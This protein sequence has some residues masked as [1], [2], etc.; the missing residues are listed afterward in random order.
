MSHPQLQPNDGSV[1]RRQFLRR[2]TLTV[3]GALAWTNVTGAEPKGRRP[4]REQAEVPVAGGDWQ[5]AAGRT[6]ALR[7]AQELRTARPRVVLD[8][9]WEFAYDRNRTA[10][11]E[12]WSAVDHPLPDS[13]RVPGCAQSEAHGAA[14]AKED[15]KGGLKWPSLADAWFRRRFEVPAAWQ[16]APVVLHVGGVHPAAEFWLNGQSLGV[17]FSS[18]SPLRCDVTAHVRWGAENVL[19]VRVF[20]PE[21]PRLD[22]LWDTAVMAWSGIYRS[23]WVERLASVRVGALTVRTTIA[24]TACTIGVGLEGERPAGRTLWVAVEVRSVGGDE[25]WRAE[26]EIPPE[27]SPAIVDIDLPLPGARLWAPHSPQLYFASARVIG[28]EVE[29]DQAE[30]RFGLREIRTAGKQVLLNG[31]PIFLRGGADDQSYPETVCPPATKDFF[32]QRLRTARE[33]GFNYTKSCVEIFTQ[34]FLE[35]ADEV[36]ML[37]CQEMP[38][39]LHGG[40][41][42]VRQKP[43][44]EWTG[45]WETELGN[46]IRADRHHPCVVIYSMASELAVRA[47]SELSFQTFNQRLPA[48]ARALHPGALVMDVTGAKETSVDTAM[49]RR[50][51]DLIENAVRR[52]K[53]VQRDPLDGPLTVPDARTCPRPFLLHEYQWWTSLPDP[54][55]AP[56]YARTALQFGAAPMMVRNATVNRIAAEVPQCVR[57]SR[58]LKYVL[59]KDGLEVA[60][61]HP[62]VAGYHFWL[63]HDFHWCPEGILDEFWRPPQGISA[64]QFR[65]AND[66]TVLLLDDGD[67]R[68][69]AGGTAPELGLQVSHY[70][71]YELG[72]AT[73][74]WQVGAE[75]G[76]ADQGIGDLPRISPGSLLRAMTIRPS[77]PVSEAPRRLQLS[78]RVLAA[79]RTVC[80]NQW[81]LWVFPAGAAVLALPEVITDLAFL[82][83]TPRP[84]V[85]GAVAAA[86]AV[87]VTDQLT[88]RELEALEQGA[89]I[90]L[91]SQGALREYHRADDPEWANTNTYRTI[92]YLRGGHGNMGTVVRAHPALGDYPH[93]GWCDLNFVHLISGAYP[94]DLTPFGPGHIPP[95]IRSIDHFKTMADKAYLFEVAVGRGALLATG[96][97]FAATYAENPATRYLLGA[98]LR[99]AGSD[100]FRPSVAVSRSTLE[101]ALSRS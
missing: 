89:R 93:D 69:F 48:L 27:S 60:R 14:A 23:I 90:V 58:L 54:A 2:A 98:M 55:L 13:S 85:G 75:S 12:G 51:T 30:V 43:T 49:G 76:A 77:L 70:G 18:R 38:F 68:C 32:L 88:G 65:Q 87:I 84:T 20:W 101:R 59:Q 99:Y 92:E 10:V 6:S 29:L 57:N 64:A 11:R 21:G 3:G 41:R 39:G 53:G 47:Q 17:T 16:G 82:R 35:A 67:R 44:P 52:R 94:I 96:L 83:E 40:Y 5:W 86:R 24:P 97:R 34:E 28:G 61:R 66:D 25:R 26:K 22:G 8:G 56:D 50:D 31:T 45:L 46:I 1:S 63:I 78:A 62:D 72:G 81:D 73:V 36:G 91:L 79:G 7:A 95:I 15:G 80:E 9:T 71:P 33:F 100:A 74:Q 37:V 19:T 42:A 4:R